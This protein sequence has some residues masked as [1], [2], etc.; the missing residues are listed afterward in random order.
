MSILHLLLGTMFGWLLSRSG[1]ADYDFIQRMF[2]FEDIQ[3]FGIIGTAIAVTAPGLYLIKKRGRTL[4]G[5]PISVAPKPRH[6]G[7]LLGGILFGAGWSITGMCPGPIFV[8]IGEGKIYALAALAGA[9]VGAG[10]FGALYPRLA[11][12]CGLPPLASGPG[13]G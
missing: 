8:S 5:R 13:D 11:S 9:L 4:L 1:A 10:M 2:L 7:N 6:P 12:A 3:L